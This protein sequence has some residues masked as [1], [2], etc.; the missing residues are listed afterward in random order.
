MATPSWKVSGQYY[1]TCN[2]DFVCPCILQQMSAAP[3]KGECLFAMAFKIDAG[4][5]RRDPARRPRVHRAGPD[6][7]GDGSGQLVG[8]GDCRPASDRRTARRHRLDC[9]RGRRWPDGGTLGLVG[10]FLGAESAPIDFDRSG[11]KWTVRAADLVD[12]GAEGV[13]GLEPR[14]GRA[15]PPGQ[16]RASGERLPRAVSGVEEPRERPR[17]GVGRPQRNEQRPLCAVRLAGRVALDLAK[18]A[19]GVP[20][21]G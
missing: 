10:R 21:D 4:R 15:A 13:D 6:A 20:R 16:R 2:C 11:V 7:G 8:R 9:E 18:G 19:A 14:G 3:S 17:F 1:E 5:L 12:M